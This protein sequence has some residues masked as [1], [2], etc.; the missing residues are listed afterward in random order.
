VAEDGLGQ[1]VQHAWFVARSN[2]QTKDYGIG[3]ALKIT[4][5]GPSSAGDIDGDSAPGLLSARHQGHLQDLFSAP[6][7]ETEPMP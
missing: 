5:R 7:L 2:Q 6:R 4:R 3:H 1:A